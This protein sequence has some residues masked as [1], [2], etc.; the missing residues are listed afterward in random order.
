M[1]LKKM[2]V[3]FVQQLVIKHIA[4]KTKNSN[5]LFTLIIANEMNQSAHKM[6]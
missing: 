3:M 1:H 5:Y 4:I 6:Y 2:D